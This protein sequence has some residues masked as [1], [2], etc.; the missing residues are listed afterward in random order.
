MRRS[1]RQKCVISASPTIVAGTGGFAATL[2]LLETTDSGLSTMK[3]G[4]VKPDPWPSLEYMDIKDSGITLPSA[5]NT[6]SP[7]A[8]HP[9]LR[10]T[11]SEY[12]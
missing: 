10:N 8:I 4:S 11:Q 2:K 7:Q 1:P 5:S 3:P 9:G 6:N 12:R